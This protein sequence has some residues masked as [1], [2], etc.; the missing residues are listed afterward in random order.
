MRILAHTLPAVV[1]RPDV[2]LALAVIGGV[3]VAWFLLSLVELLVDLRRA[4]TDRRHVEQLDTLA[5]AVGVLVDHVEQLNATA[6]DH[7]AALD[8]IRDAVEQP[9]TAQPAHL[10][11][12]GG[13]R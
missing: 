10:T 7:L 4:R 3:A 12:A 6:D 11:V 1:E 13:A 2:A 9:T 5:D 8:A